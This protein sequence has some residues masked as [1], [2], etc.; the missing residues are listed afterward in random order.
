[1]SSTVVCTRGNK[2]QRA[3]QRSSQA[4]GHDRP[5]TYA[6]ENDRGRRNCASLFLGVGVPSTLNGVLMRLQFALTKRLAV[7][8]TGRGRR[9]SHR[10]LLPANRRRNEQVLRRA[11]SIETVVDVLQPLYA[12]ALAALPGPAADVVK[13]IVGED[14]SVVGLII[15]F[16]VAFLSLMTAA[17]VFAR[18]KT[19]LPPTVPGGLPLLGNMLQLK[20][21]K[22]HKTFTKWV[23]QLGP[24]FHVKMGSID[25]VVISSAELAKEVL[26][27]HF[28][29]V[30][31]RRMTT[32]MRIL[33]GNKTMVAMSDYGEEHRMLKKMVVGNL[34]GM[35]A[36]RANRAIREDA[37]NTMI[38]EMFEDLKGNEGVL[39]IRR[40]IQYA[41]FPFSMRQVFG[42]VPDKLIVEGLGELGK[43]DIFQILV[44]DP[45]KH[46]I[47][48]DWRNY[49]P[50]LSWVPNT[51]LEKR[52]N[53]T[54]ERKLTVMGALIEEQRKLLQTREP[55]RCYADIVLMEYPNLSPLQLKH[56]LWEPIIESA[57]TSLVTS[58][59]A[60]YE[61]A[62]N[63]TIQERL[64]SEIISVVG[65]SRMVTEDDYPNLPFLEAIIKETLRYYTPVTILPPRYVHED[66]KVGG[67]V[68]PKDWD[69]L[70]NL[71][72]INWDPKVW[73]NPEVWNPDRCLGD[74]TLDLGVKDFRIVPFGG[75]KRMCAGMTQAFSIIPM[76]VAAIVQHFELSLPPDENI[77]AEDTVYLTSHKLHPLRALL[78]PR[79]AQRLPSS[80]K[81]TS[82]AF[83]VKSSQSC[84]AH[85]THVDATQAKFCPL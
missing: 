14:F 55:T 23:Q 84:P 76:N 74:K 32:A 83:E 13:Y 75:G 62:R 20:E 17:R 19:N 38:D 45:L 48:V 33:T 24:I 22:P 59:W 12:R 61:I 60:L 54:H 50:A 26:V 85:A 44:L 66:I 29:S 8:R 79:V 9:S 64:Y 18:K 49:F 72:G 28:E 40:S 34:L 4:F 36:Q 21:K 82:S 47:E 37:L 46:V 69:V 15:S 6:R 5:A 52:V 30:S 65:T 31:T 53:D 43:W 56:S 25:N 63:P 70:I 35:S 73:S 68:I 1:M 11:M 77:N 78:K 27:T 57:D 42:Y 39:D 3:L 80:L 41:L 67:F 71:Y 16:A 51:Q 81:S 58:E 7:A 2:S 10:L